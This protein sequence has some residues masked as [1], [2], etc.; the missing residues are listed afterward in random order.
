M[1]VP[2]IVNIVFQWIQYWIWFNL[3]TRENNMTNSQNL[4]ISIELPSDFLEEE[5]R[6]GYVVTSKLKK[7]W[8]VELDLLSTFLKVCNEHDIKV[9][10]FAGSLL[11]AIRHKG[12]I[13]WDDDLD[14]CMDRKNFKKLLRL[15]ADTFKAPYF[16]QTALTDKAHFLPYARLRNSLTTACI[17]GMDS[18][19]YNN[20]IFIDIH[21][22]DGY[23]YNERLFNWQCGVKNFFECCLSDF[24]KKE[25][26]LFTKRVFTILRPLLTLL[27]YKNLYKIHCFILQML[28]WRTDRMSILTNDIQMSR[29][30]ILHK[31]EF[32]DSIY[33]PF[34]MINVPVPKEYSKVLTRIYG[35]YLQFPKEEER[36]RWHEGIITFDPETPYIEFINNRKI[37][38][39]L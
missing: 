12:F 23:V 34:E 32:D 20:G 11:G 18:A 3:V 14:L 36:G 30:Y 21:V 33:V 10:V 26:Q 2:L 7:I 25:P 35:D 31:D 22:L 15:P 17:T 16:L 6:D 9:Q 8:A 4:P 19:D 24:N 1:L 39:K 5:V 27:G 38:N 13:P 37:K 28:N 29:K